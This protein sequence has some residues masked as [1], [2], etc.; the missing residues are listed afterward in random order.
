MDEEQRWLDAGVEMDGLPC[1][2]CHRNGTAAWLLGNN[3]MPDIA[4]HSTMMR[5]AMMRGE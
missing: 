2:D 3:A 1:R 4:G 5:G